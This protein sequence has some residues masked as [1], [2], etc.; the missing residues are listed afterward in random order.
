MK[1]DGGVRFK[2]QVHGVSKRSAI[3]VIFALRLPTLFGSNK[4]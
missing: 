1:A 2:I 3:V 4:K